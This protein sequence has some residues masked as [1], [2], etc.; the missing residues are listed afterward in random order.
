MFYFQ[1]FN[2]P[3]VKIYQPKLFSVDKQ[4]VFLKSF[5]R[6]IPYSVPCEQRPFD[7]VHTVPTGPT[8][9][10]RTL[11]TRFDFHILKEKHIF[12]WRRPSETPHIFPFPFGIGSSLD[13]LYRKNT[14][15]RFKTI[16]LMIILFLRRL[17]TASRALPRSC[18]FRV[19]K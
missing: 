15:N 8:A 16:L 12:Y 17:H 7:L 9:G 19:V 4:A 18:S 13:A 11:F 10:Q 2:S 3:G 6:K 5:I 1:S 14:A